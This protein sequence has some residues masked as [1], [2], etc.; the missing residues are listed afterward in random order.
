MNLFSETKMDISIK[1]IKRDGQDDKAVAHFM[2]T[3]IKLL[4]GQRGNMRS[5]NLQSTLM[6]S[7]VESPR[8][9]RCFVNRRYQHFFQQCSHFR[10]T[11]A[12]STKKAKLLRK[13]V[14]FRFDNAEKGKTMDN[15]F[16]L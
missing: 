5:H 1:D 3:M 14:F 8:R 9:A 10:A 4:R 12:F 2:I 7:L 16:F 11:V 15:I 13:N 6:I